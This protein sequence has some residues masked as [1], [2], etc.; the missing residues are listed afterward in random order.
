LRRIGHFAP[1]AIGIGQRT[2]VALLAVIVILLAGC[3][4]PG[5]V[6]PSIKIGLVAPFEGRYRYIGY[7]VLYAVRLAL[8]EANSDGGVG[9]Y[10]VE[11]VAYD[12]R[13][14]PELAIQQAR[15]LAVDP[16]VVAVIGHFQEQTTEAAAPVYDDSG[17][18]LVAPGMLSSS[19]TGDYEGVFRLGP[20][21]CA[22]A[23]GILDC[24]EA[25]PGDA[26]LGLVG[27]E[28]Y[29][30]RAILLEAEAGGIGVEV[31]TAD[32]ETGWLDVLP[33]LASPLVC[34]AEPLPAGRAASDLRA[35]GWTGRLYGGPALTAGDFASVAG[36]AAE[37]ALALTPW[38]F[39]GDVPGSDAFG[40]SYEAM[41]YHV[42]PPGTLALPAYEATW[43]LLEA[44]ERDIEE[45]GVP[46]RA[47]MASA[48][49]STSRTGLLGEI[50]F[51]A[52]GEWAGAPLYWYEIQPDGLPLLVEDPACA[53]AP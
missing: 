49:P 36:G 40:E 50:V 45:N 21:A 4:F 23:Q 34:D 15:K 46:S 14:D 29:L 44:L 12:D 13:G 48:I 31:L 47:G 28:G 41:G 32:G 24:L 33:D 6:R 26:G 7:D 11:L 43:L 35:L 16:Q 39:P 3:R 51:D 1:G 8:R 30:G 53:A 38:P 37:G 20:P 52:A 22:L 10:S 5:S 2:G 18:P 17:I 9:G 27:A 42:G 25:E 19:L